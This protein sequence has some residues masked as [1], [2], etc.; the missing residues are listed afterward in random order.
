MRAASTKRAFPLRKLSI[1]L[2]LALG[3]CSFTETNE[4]TGVVPLVSPEPSRP[5]AIRPGYDRLMTVDKLYAWCEY[6]MLKF[7]VTA[8]A[9]SGGWKGPRLNRLPTEG[10]A[11]AYEAVAVRPSGAA[12]QALQSFTFTHQEPMPR[13]SG[14]VRVMGQ[15]NEMSTAIFIGKGC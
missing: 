8:T 15:S 6:G 12:S 4:G 10:N 13:G 3:G 7:Q 5:N 11:P 1:L 14:R 2:A 9:N